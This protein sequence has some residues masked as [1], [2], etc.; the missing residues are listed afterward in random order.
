MFHV[1]F[2]PLER[3]ECLMFSLGLSRGEYFSYQAWAPR[4]VK[5][6]HVDFGPF[7]ESKCFISRVGQT[8]SC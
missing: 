3:L 8:V 7:K 5:M 6:F 4:G 1:K 2:G